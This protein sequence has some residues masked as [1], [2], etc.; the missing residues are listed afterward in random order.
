MTKFRTLAQP[1][2]VSVYPHE[3]DALLRIMAELRVKSTFDVVRV[4]ARESNR[5]H[6]DAFSPPKFK[7]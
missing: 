6:M 5:K 7:S 2:T 3:R 1:M 4:L